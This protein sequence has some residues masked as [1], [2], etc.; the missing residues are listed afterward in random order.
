MSWEKTVCPE[1]ILIVGNARE[2]PLQCN[3]RT[4]RQI[5]IE[6]SE[7]PHIALITIGYI[8]QPDLAGHY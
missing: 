7:L 8:G 2:V 6:K 4:M 3:P 1:F 5:Q